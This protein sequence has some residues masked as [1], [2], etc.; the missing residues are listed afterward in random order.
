M[1][2]VSPPTPRGIAVRTALRVGWIALRLG[3]V[4]LFGRRGALFFYQGF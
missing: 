4:I 1:S 3:L 2:E